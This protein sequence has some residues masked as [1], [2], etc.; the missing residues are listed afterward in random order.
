MRAQ[1]E[2][3]VMT[4]IP[5]QRDDFAR[6]NVHHFSP[7]PHLPCKTKTSQTHPSSLS[8]SK[9]R[10]SRLSGT[11]SLSACPIESCQERGRWTATLD[12]S[13]RLRCVRR[14]HTSDAVSDASEKSTPP[15]PLAKKVDL[16]NRSRDCIL[17]MGLNAKIPMMTRMVM[18]E[19]SSPIRQKEPFHR[20]DAPRKVAPRFAQ[21]DLVPLLPPM[22]MP[23]TAI[24]SASE[25]SARRTYCGVCAFCSRSP[26]VL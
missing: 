26:M 9:T 11:R 18:E 14:T 7:P 1:C 25:R 21:L 3:R 24:P 20:V 10:T 23:G 12:I 22:S 4:C 8:H 13:F 2:C 15:K 19:N 17:Y 6:S 5:I 16:L